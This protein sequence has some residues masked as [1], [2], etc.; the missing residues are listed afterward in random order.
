MSFIGIVV[1][2]ASILW[3]RDIVVGEEIE[4]KRFLDGRFEGFK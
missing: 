4:D 3:V 2:S 1:L